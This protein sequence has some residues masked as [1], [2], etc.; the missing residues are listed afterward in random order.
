M[1]MLAGEGQKDNV[2]AFL[3]AALELYGERG[4][5]DYSSS[6]SSKRCL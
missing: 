6:V 5:L 3:A 4:E 2:D 1:C